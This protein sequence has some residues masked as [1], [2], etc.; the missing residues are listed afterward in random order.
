MLLNSMMVNTEVWSSVT[1]A[2]INV[3]HKSDVSLLHKFY[4]ISAK[5]TSEEVLFLE[6]GIMP[7]RFLISKRRLMYC[8][9]IL[10]CDKNEMIAKAY[11]CQKMKPVKNDFYSLIQRE[12]KLFNIQYSDE[13]ISS[14]SKN[15]FK[16][17]VYQ[18]VDKFAFSYLLRRSENHSKAK[19]IVKSIS[20]YKFKRQPYLQCEYFSRQEAQLCFKLRSRSLDLKSN[21]KMKYKN[22]LAC[23]TCTFGVEETEAHLLL[24]SGL[25]L[26]D[27][28]PS[29]KYE[30]LFL[31]LKSQISVTKFYMKKLRRREV[32]L[33]LNDEQ[34]ST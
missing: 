26:E 1:D 8:W 18:Q 12:K 7:L 34:P 9:E 33:D 22:D 16:K 11:F 5:A 17:I 14:M 15:R 6:G 4:G 10:S 3:L 27:D 13:E 2:Q 20:E 31:D 32:I 29:F 25:K 21:F 30:Q 24:C 23:R 28:D 19:Y